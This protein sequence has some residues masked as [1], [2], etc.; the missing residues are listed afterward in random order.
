MYST[1]H[2]K[3]LREMVCQLR[4]QLSSVNLNQQTAMVTGPPLVHAVQSLWPHSEVP[5]GRRTRSP[6]GSRQ[7]P[8]SLPSCDRSESLW[9]PRPLQGQVQPEQYF[10]DGKQRFGLN[11]S[12]V[13]TTDRL[14]RL[15]V[16]LLLAC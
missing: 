7:W 9:C 13:T 2:S 1:P 6:A 15:L 14:Q 12:T 16:A 3:R 8:A 4:M 5:P 10:R 11:R